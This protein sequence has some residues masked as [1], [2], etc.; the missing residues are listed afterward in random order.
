MTKKSF[1]TAIGKFDQERWDSI[2]KLRHSVLLAIEEFLV[3]KKYLKVTTSSLVNVAGSCEN[4]FVSFELPYYGNRKAHLSQ[5]AQIQLENMVHRGNGTSVYTVNNSFREEDH[6]DPDPAQAGRRISEFTLIEP[7]RMVKATTPDDALK[8]LIKE[9]EEV[10]KHVLKK[11]LKDNKKEIQILGGD[12][13]LLEKSVKSKFKVITY[14]EAIALLNKMG[15]KFKYYVKNGKTV[16]ESTGEKYAHGD[17]FGIREER[18]ILE[19]F[20]L[21]PTFVTHFP[22]EMKFFNMKQRED[23]ITYSADLIMWKMGETI[24]SAVR[25]CDPKIALKQLRELQVGVYLRDRGL[26]PKEIFGEYF[27]SLKDSSIKMTIGYGIGF[28]RLIGNIIQSN[29]ILNTMQHNPIA[30]GPR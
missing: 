23:G 6:N 7:E 12:I 9:E 15:G 10:I 4:P 8:Q 11:V 5:S 24:G 21:V 13:K 30:P 17:D 3:S 14:E 29:D 1:K 18:V 19:K 2:V 20:D 27:N 22:K 28:E 16:K 25:E 26:D